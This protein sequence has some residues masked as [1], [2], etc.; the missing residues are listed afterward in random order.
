MD[1]LD[2]RF[3]NAHYFQGHLMTADAGRIELT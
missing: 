3:Y 1:H 2:C